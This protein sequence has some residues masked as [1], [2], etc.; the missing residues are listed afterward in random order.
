MK[1]PIT[2]FT[3]ENGNRRWPTGQDFCSSFIQFGVSN[4]FKNWDRTGQEGKGVCG[5]GLS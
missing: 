3:M 4:D 1:K 5:A 2:V